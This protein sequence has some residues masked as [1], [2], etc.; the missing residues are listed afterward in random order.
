M[1]ISEK[2]TLLGKG[3]YKDI[4]DVLTL[5]CIPTA[6]ELDYVG[7]E[8]F[9]ATMLDL[10]F[11]KAIEEQC[12]FRNLLEIDFQW[13]CRCLRILNYGPYYT[14]NAIFCP[15]CDAISHGEYQADLRTI[16]V[17]VLPDN[18]TNSIVISKDEFIDFDGDIELKLPTIQDMM[19]A[20]KDSLFIDANGD[21]N[22]TLAR[23]CYMIKSIK[24]DSTMPIPDIK[25]AIQNQ[26]SSADF[27]VLKTRATELTDYGLRAG[28]KIC[29]PKCHSKKAAFVALVDD[30][31]FRPTLGDLRAWKADRNAK[32]SGGPTNANG[33]SGKRDEIIPRTSPTTI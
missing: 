4:P 3:L 22:L 20:N 5:K 13:I 25:F 15:D 24:G 11:P 6:S 10:I 32:K 31:F 33:E 21:A 27:F 26:L 23:L 14:T 19:N 8:D 28:G 29:C 7:G 2:I 17:K 9:N 18:F 30:R 12:N 1:A 16:D